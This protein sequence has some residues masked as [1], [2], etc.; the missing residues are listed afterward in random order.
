MEDFFFFLLLMPKSWANTKAAYHWVEVGSGLYMPWSWCPLFYHK[1]K[2][3]QH[4]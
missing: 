3:I 1:R 2:V 4:G